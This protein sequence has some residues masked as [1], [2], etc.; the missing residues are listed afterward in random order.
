[1]YWAHIFCSWVL[2][3]IPS[4]VAYSIVGWLAPLVGRFW[5]RKYQLAL[6][7][8][9]RVLG[10][11]PDPIGSY[12]MVASEFWSSN[13]AVHASWAACCALDPAPA[14]VPETPLD[15]LLLEPQAATVSARRAEAAETSHHFLVIESLLFR[16]R[17]GTAAHGLAS[18]RSF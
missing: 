14:I 3:I 18:L 11:R 17:K 6:E 15:E 10:P 7:N 9:E 2:R 4:R 1:M 8:M 16:F 13:L 12:E 5:G